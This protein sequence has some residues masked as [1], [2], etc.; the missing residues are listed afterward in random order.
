MVQSVIES[1]D[2]EPAVEQEAL[3]ELPQEE[4]GETEVSGVLDAITR[5]ID[6]GLKVADYYLTDEEERPSLE[7]L[8]ARPTEAEYLPTR[9]LE[10]ITLDIR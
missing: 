8:F 1:F 2:E 3:T 9:G 6:T 10:N 7:E 4:T 5:L